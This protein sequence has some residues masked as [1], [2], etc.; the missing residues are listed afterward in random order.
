MLLDSIERFLQLDW[1]AF[2]FHAIPGD[3]RMPIEQFPDVFPELADCLLES[4]CSR[5][6][7]HY[8]NTVNWNDDLIFCYNVLPEDLSEES[9][10]SIAMLRTMGVNVQVPSHALPILFKRFGLNVED[11]LSVPRMLEILINE[12]NCEISRID[13]C[14]DD[15]TKKFTVDFYRKA[16]AN[17]CIQSPFIRN[18]SCVGSKNTGFTF[19]VGSLKKRTKLLRIYDKF[20]QSDGKI[21]S[22]RYEF[23]VHSDQA[24][25][26]SR[27]LIN[28]YRDGI[29]FPSFLIGW[30][31]IKVDDAV[32]YSKI[33]NAPMNKDWESWLYSINSQFN[34]K[35]RILIP[36]SNLDESMQETF[37]FV[38]QQAFKSVAGYVSIKGWSYF[39]H[40]INSLI[41]RDDI[42]EK[43]KYLKRK[44]SASDVFFEDSLYSDKNPF[45]LT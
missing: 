10:R 25:A 28:E 35:I 37:R 24:R 27:M 5:V 34:A 29:D 4:E 41:K 2:T 13:L 26:L 6:R 22:I 7:S 43:Y 11:P 38:E 36:K 14:Y 33:T 44:L 23:E 30:I 40:E 19:Y 39:Q 16:W 31:R 18:I 17:D 32:D 45:Y 21:D 12:R 8:T 1:L 15:F 42:P 3:D 9:L 20:L